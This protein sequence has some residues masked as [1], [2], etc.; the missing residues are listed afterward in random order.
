MK[1]HFKYIMIISLRISLGLVFLWAF[2]DKTFGLSFATKPENAWI[3]GGSPTTGFLTYATK[4]PF[5]NF[6]QNLAGNALVDWMFMLGL[7]FVGITLFFNKFM[8]W[9]SIAGSVMLFLMYIAALPPE[10]NPLIDDH[11]IYILLLGFLATE[12]KAC[13]RCNGT[14]TDHCCAECKKD[15]GSDLCSEHDGCC[16]PECRQKQ[17]N[18]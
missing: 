15:I 5:A 18:K 16:G 7:L 4:G 13:Y 3:Q 11:I 12:S 10:N 9:G 6:F 8:K 17:N 2:F 14:C 1:K